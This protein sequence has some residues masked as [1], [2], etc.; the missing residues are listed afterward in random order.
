MPTALFVSLFLAHSQAAAPVCTAWG[1]SELLATCDDCPRINESSGV[2]PARHREGVWFTHND[3][4]GS[5]ELYAFDTTGIHLET[6]SVL[7]GGFRDW[8]DIAT[9]PCPAGVDAE[10][11]IF[12]GDVGDN[13][14]SREEIDIWVVAEPTVGEP[15]EV[16]A[17]WRLRYPVEPHD[18]EAIVV[19]PCT[20]RIYL[21]TKE[22]EGEPMVFRVP[23]TPT[24]PDSVVEVELVATLSRTW[25]GDSGLVTGADWSEAGD[26][27]AMRTY[28]GGWVWQTD[29]ADPDG[30]W[31]TP[32][33]PL[34]ID[35]EGQGESIA[36]HPDG[37]VLTTT[38][39]TPM[40]IVHLPCDTSTDPSECPP[41]EP[42]DT[43][44]PPDTGSAEDTAC[45]PDTGPEDEPGPIDE[46][47]T[48]EDDQRDDSAVSPAVDAAPATPP[49]DECGCG[50]GASAWVVVWCL[51]GLRRR[52]SVAED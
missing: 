33:T 15:A 21:L 51:L 29:P 36:F 24:G 28:D 40:R 2:V 16:V 26:Q 17:S 35:I 32:P 7:G 10:T 19:H 34:P 22:R 5:A 52:R 31:S 49:K 20:G 13:G 38:E 8:E 41:P 30:H 47:D 39:R 14:S 27:L 42:E 3:A 50:D 43:G 25:F 12:I 6:H 11:C 4:G 23:A 46:D 45:C 1:E 18:C 44:S 9:G 48:Q 37:G